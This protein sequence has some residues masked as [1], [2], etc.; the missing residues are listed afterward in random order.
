MRDVNIA[1]YNWGTDERRDMSAEQHLRIL[2]VTGSTNDEALSRARG[3]APHGTAVAARR[4]T[5]G[6]GRRGHTWE[7]PDGNLYL[8]VVLRPQVTPTRLPGLA[9]ACGLGVLDALD[10]LGISNE[11]Q[12]KW[13][14]DLLARG[15]KL[16]GILV[17]T[18][19]DDAGQTFAICGVGVNVERAPRG[20][21]AICLAELGGAPSFSPLAERLR[22]G[23]VSRVDA[24][25]AAPGERP[26]D[27][28]RDDYLARLAWRGEKVHVLAA[29]DGAELARGTL[30][31]VDPWGRA[32]VSGV[33][34]A[35]ELVSLRPT[36]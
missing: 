16:A 13:P 27:G 15:L 29:T 30:E 20:L 36:D 19:R 35:S 11:A 21:G 18:A 12:L 28:I 32:V 33:P 17:E 1:P 24:W 22:S 3:G 9:A 6:R 7:S 5:A 14:N 25:A 10:T 34:Y 8:S 2:D 26:L 23:V 4:Q 31:T